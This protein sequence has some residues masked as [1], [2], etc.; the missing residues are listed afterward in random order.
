MVKKNLPPSK[1]KLRVKSKQ[2]KFCRLFVDGLFKIMKKIMKIILIFFG[3]LFLLFLINPIIL[4]IFNS[5]IVFPNI[6][7][8]KCPSNYSHPVQMT[9]SV[10]KTICKKNKKTCTPGQTWIVKKGDCTPRVIGCVFDSPC[11]CLWPL[12][13]SWDKK[14]KKWICEENK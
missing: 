9:M 3:I 14:E 2:F 5:P 1:E 11:N 6:I 4:P 8:K 10:N 12:D 13:W 7:F